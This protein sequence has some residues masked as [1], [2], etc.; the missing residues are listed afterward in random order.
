MFLVTAQKWGRD[1]ASGEMERSPERFGMLRMQEQ[2]R[3]WGFVRILDPVQARQGAR[4][5]ADVGLR[6]WEA[7]RHRLP[8]AERKLLWDTEAR[9]WG[10]V[11]EL[12]RRM[13]ELPDRHELLCA[14]GDRMA[15]LE[16][17]QEWLMTR[18]TGDEAWG[19]TRDAASRA[20]RVRERLLQRSLERGRGLER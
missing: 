18:A 17:G 8:A 19:T 10:G 13:K 9:L 20:L 2:R 16:A 12:E 4:Q 7:E 5:A 1:F 11:R 14:V 3:L 15:E 6:Y